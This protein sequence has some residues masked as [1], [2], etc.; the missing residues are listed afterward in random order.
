MDGGGG[1]KT[2]SVTELLRGRI[3][4]LVFE[5]FA[6]VGFVSIRS[7]VT[8]HFSGLD[9]DDR[10]ALIQVPVGDVCFVRFCIHENRS[11]PAEVLRIITV[12]DQCT[13][14]ICIGRAVPAPA[15]VSVLFN[16]LS[17]PGKSENV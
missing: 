9:I 14:A 3:I 15:R 11:G 4:G 17:V 5:N 6:I 8:L 2:W 13:L 12:C 16:E 7:P 1:W 10:N